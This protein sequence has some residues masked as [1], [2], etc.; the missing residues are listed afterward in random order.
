MG[1]GRGAAGSRGQPG[2]G[3]GGGC[4]PP[5]VA[6]AGRSRSPRRG[7][8]PAALQ[9]RSPLRESQAARSPRRDGGRCASRSATALVFLSPA[10]IFG[11]FFFPPPSAKGALKALK[12]PQHQEAVLLSSHSRGKG[13]WR[14]LWYLM[15]FE[16]YSSNTFA[17]SLLAYM[18]E[19][20]QIRTR[21]EWF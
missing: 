3:G 8:S 20:S 19:E 4:L 12:L 10:P 7:R 21:T 2:A 1:A 16:R 17:F 6:A 18:G 13:S 9:G 5:R 11:F 14:L 15:S